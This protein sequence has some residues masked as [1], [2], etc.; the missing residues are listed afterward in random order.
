[1]AE[2]KTG[3]I[4]QAARALGLDVQNEAGLTITGPR[5]EARADA[6]FQAERRKLC[7]QQKFPYRGFYAFFVRAHREQDAADGFRRERVA[8]YWPNYVGQMPMGN[9]AGMRRHRPILSALFPGLI[10]SPMA[11]ADLLWAAAQRVPYVI[12]MLRR[13][14][15][16][17]AVLSNS[18]IEIIRH[19]E[20][21]ANGPPPVRPV[22][23]F[24]VGD[25]V[26]FVDDKLV[27]WPPGKVIRLDADGR[28]S[29]E[30]YLMMRAVPMHGILPHQIERM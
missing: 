21:D 30:V 22:H 17:P 3:N 11:D 7:D 14:G 4:A 1:M 20:S 28:I 23:N 13:D 6:V 18:D 9:H 27:I 16:E 26:R 8:A 25:K 12:N 24:K 19:I 15:G 29:V 2:R 10:F 5:A